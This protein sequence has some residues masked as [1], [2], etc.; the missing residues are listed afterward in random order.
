MTF[1]NENKKR[2]E[3]APTTNNVNTTIAKTSVHSYQIIKSLITINPEY[4]SLVYP[5]SKSEYELLK[6]SIKEK[7]LHL[8][9][10]VNQDNV[11]LDGH[12]RYK[13]CKELNIEPRFEVKRFD[14]PLDEKEFVIEINAQRR[15]LN[16]F[17]KAEFVIIF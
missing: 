2:D 14:D 4:S 1:E 5:L 10:I 17:Q 15:Q 6:R 11:I 9:I 3:I 16:D 12:H 13:I 8:P 7:G